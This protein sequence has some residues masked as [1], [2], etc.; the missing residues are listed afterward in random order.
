MSSKEKHEH[1]C[2]T[3]APQTIERN[4]YRKKEQRE[5]LEVGQHVS[6]GLISPPFV[7]RS[8]SVC[9]SPSHDD[10]DDDDDDDEEDFMYDDG[11]YDDNQLG[12]KEGVRI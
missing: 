6:E 1:V 11:T 7:P 3:A 5:P 10:D 8:L 4:Q 9:L 12:K 2:H